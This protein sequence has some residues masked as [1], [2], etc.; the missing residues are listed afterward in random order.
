MTNIGEKN[1][2]FVR[3]YIRTEGL[4]LIG[5]DVGDLFPRKVAYHPR[6]GKVKVKKMRSM[7]NRTI[8]DREEQ[9]MHSIEQ[10]PVAGDV[11]LF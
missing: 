11:E 7:H 8:R 9:Y 10:K 6:S 1:I 3:D 2:A 5:E 4:N